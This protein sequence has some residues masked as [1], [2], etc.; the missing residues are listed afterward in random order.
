V[1]YYLDHGAAIDWEACG[2]LSAGGSA[3]IGALLYFF[4]FRSRS[5]NCRAYFAMVGA[6]LGE[7]GGLSFSG[8]NPSELTHNTDDNAWSFLQCNDYF[9]LSNLNLSV[10]Q[11]F[12]EGASLGYGYSACLISAGLFPVLFARQNCSGWG[13]GVGIQITACTGVFDRRSRDSMRLIAA[14]ETAFRR[15]LGGSPR[16]KG[17]VAPPTTLVGTP[18]KW[19]LTN[20]FDPRERAEI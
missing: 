3:G 10:G 9:S 18:K 2:V 15:P 20:E 12:S 4:E 7:G 5:A 1:S 17:A 16:V 11:I 14:S 13:S 19:S 8:G 6:A